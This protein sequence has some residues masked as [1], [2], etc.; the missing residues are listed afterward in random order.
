M[1]NDRKV[2][3]YY[4]FNIQKYMAIYGYKAHYP[5]YYKLYTWCNFKYKHMAE[6]KV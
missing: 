6:W 3:K 1:Y 5:N 2:I 4:S